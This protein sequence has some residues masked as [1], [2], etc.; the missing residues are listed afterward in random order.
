MDLGIPENTPRSWE[1]ETTY[2][3]ALMRSF[4]FPK[5]IGATEEKFGGRYGVPGF[6]GFL[7][8]PAWKVSLEASKVFQKNLFSKCF[9]PFECPAFKLL[10]TCRT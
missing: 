3:P 5:E 2:H 4:S 8:L 6:L 9:L 7:Y 1:T 10:I